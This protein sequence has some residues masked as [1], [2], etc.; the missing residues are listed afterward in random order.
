[1]VLA[2]QLVEDRAA[3]ARHGERAER[4]SAL[5]VERAHRGHE[6]ERAGA[7]QLVVIELVAQLALELTRDVMHEAQVFGEESIAGGQIA[8]GEGLPRGTRFHVVRLPAGLR[9]GGTFQG[10]GGQRAGT[11]CGKT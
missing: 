5:R 4:E 11:A 1:M 7:H 9:S 2:T 10:A 6:A 8:V 3:N